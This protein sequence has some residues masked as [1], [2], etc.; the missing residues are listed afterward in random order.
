MKF[1]EDGEMEDL[2]KDF[3]D[4]AASTDNDIKI[5]PGNNIASPPIDPNN[6]ID[7]PVDTDL[8]D[9]SELITAEFCVSILDRIYPRFFVGLMNNFSKEKISA[10]EIRLDK[11]EQR[12]LKKT[13]EKVLKKITFKVEPW[14]AFIIQY[15]MMLYVKFEEAKEERRELKKEGQPADNIDKIIKQ[16]SEKKISAEKENIS[17]P[18]RKP[19]P[20]DEQGNIIGK[21][22]YTKKK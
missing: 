9:L 3:K 20:R 5:E 17:R 19:L 4:N 2:L 21:G 18:G 1:E 22:K 13:A 8:F 7:R 12:Q 6:P 16:A 15:H 10:K 11:D 14:K